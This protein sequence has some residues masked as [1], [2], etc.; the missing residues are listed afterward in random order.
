MIYSSRLNSSRLPY[1]TVPPPPPSVPVA[2]CPPF[3]SRLGND[4]ERL[5]VLTGWLTAAAK[6]DL[7]LA[8]AVLEGCLADPR[9]LGGPRAVR[10]M[11]MWRRIPIHVFFWAERRLR[12]FPLLRLQFASMVEFFLRTT[13]KP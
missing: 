4:P 1:T 2:G 8:R 13:V 3:L 12:R 5:R 10:G 6:Q 7:G 9:P 11:R